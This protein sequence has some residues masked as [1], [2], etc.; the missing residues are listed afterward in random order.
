VLNTP[1][2]V[3]NPFASVTG[4]SEWEAAAIY[5][6]LEGEAPR[7]LWYPSWYWEPPAPAFEE[8]LPLKPI[9]VRRLRMPLCGT[10]VQVG[11]YYNGL[12]GSMRWLKPRRLILLCNLMSR[13][14]LNAR[15]DEVEALGLRD[16]TEFV[17][18]SELVR[19]WAGLDGFVAPSPIDL[20]RFTFLDRRSR[21]DDQFK[22]GRLSRDTR[23]K[24][25]A[26]DPAFFDRLASHGM[27][28]DVLGGTCLTGELRRSDHIIRPGGSIDAV[29]FLHEL[30]CFFYR[31]PEDRAEPFGRVVVEAMATGLPVVAQKEGG[32]AT[33]MTH[34]RDC[35][36]FE[37]A[38]EALAYLKTLQQDTN[39]RHTIGRRARQTVE[40]LYGPEATQEMIDFYTR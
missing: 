30:D 6:M 8:Q 16:R 5:E 7:R 40:E 2:H 23:D 31:L 14:Q 11:L 26:D 12:P 20:D 1:I 33:Y 17:F 24:Y 32:Y 27:Q 28:V 3:I 10:V 22:V 9:D 25:H 39:L 37:D 21:P 29:E 34:G 36:L 15:L 18:C 35:F 4:G 19:A 13:H 38:D